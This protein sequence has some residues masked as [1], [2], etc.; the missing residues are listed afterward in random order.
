MLDDFIEANKL[1]AKILD[2]GE[3]VH[4]AKAAA[5]LMNVPLSK[6]LKSI[7]FVDKDQN[8][9]LALVP[10]DQNVDTAKLQKVTGSS[11]LRLASEKEVFEMTGYEIGGVPPV[12]IFGVKTVLDSCFSPSDSVFAGGGDN[13]HLVLIPIKEIKEFGTDLTVA[14]ISEPL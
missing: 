14:D 12:S 9:V 11:K 4:S 8:G 7:L 13:S 2:C 6:V 3:E 1:S 10:G 5:R